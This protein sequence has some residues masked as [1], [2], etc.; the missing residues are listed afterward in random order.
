MRAR[1]R[2]PRAL[3]ANTK[4]VRHARNVTITKARRT[5]FI[6]P[7]AMIHTVDPQGRR[8]SATFLID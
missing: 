7:Q 2:E 3:V 4:G 8:A 5:E 1:H 6:A